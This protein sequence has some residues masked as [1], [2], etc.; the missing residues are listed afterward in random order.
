MERR[1]AMFFLLVDPDHVKD[2]VNP[3]VV[4]SCREGFVDAVLVGGSLMMRDGTGRVV[5]RLR[6]ETQVP[7]I[8]FPGNARQLC[9]EATAVLY[10]SLISGRNPHYLIGE[11]VLASPIIHEMGMEAIPTGYMLIES[12]GRTTAEYISNTIPIPRDKSDIAVAHALAAQHLGMKLVYL[13][14]GSGAKLS[15]PDEMVAEVAAAVSLP[16]LVGG[17]I[18]SPEGAA[19]KVAHGA[20]GIIIGQAIEDARSS[21]IIREFADAIHTSD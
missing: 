10:L 7:V 18:R 8:L 3:A 15:V 17:G 19:E 14:G 1:G 2:D 9:P 13:E 21:G 4:E 6:E 5:A 11:H 20:K 12:G 16:V